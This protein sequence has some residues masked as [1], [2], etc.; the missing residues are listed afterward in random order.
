LTSV[1]KAAATTPHQWQDWYWVCVGGEVLFLP[2]M[3]VLGGRWRPKRARQ[4]AEEHE[5]KVAEEL[6]ALQAAN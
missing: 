3:L 5:K 1:E 4:D 2:F 6:A